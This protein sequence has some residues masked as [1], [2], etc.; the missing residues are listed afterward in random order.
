MLVVVGDKALGFGW[1]D[2]GIDLRREVQLDL[3]GVR[4]R[5]NRAHISLNTLQDDRVAV[6]KV[7]ADSSNIETAI[8]KPVDVGVLFVVLADQAYQRQIRPKQPQQLING[9]RSVQQA[10][11]VFRAVSAHV[12]VS[13]TPYLVDKGLDR[14]RLKQP[15]Q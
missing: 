8:G 1:R 9:G 15:G 11:E 14:Q 12:V 2:V 7:F 13:R 4:Q 5:G 10:V 3:D 6:G